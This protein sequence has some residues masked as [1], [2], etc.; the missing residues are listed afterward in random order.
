MGYH[1]I[2]N[3]VP[4]LQFDAFIFREFV[5][6]AIKIK[7]IRHTVD[8]NTFVEK[9]FPDEVEALRSHTLPL[10]VLRELSGYVLRTSGHGAGS[11][12]FRIPQER[13]GSTRQRGT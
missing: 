1:W 13:S 10:H 7:K 9:L 3:T 4:A 11:I 8:E 2:T 12:S 6:S 5:I